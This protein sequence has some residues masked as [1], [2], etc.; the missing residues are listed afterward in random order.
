MIVVN[1]STN[2]LALIIHHLA[3]NSDPA[4]RLISATSLISNT[5]L[6]TAD[7]NMRKTKELRIIW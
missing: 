5:T 4:N 2:H 3:I 7:K 6:I 1:V